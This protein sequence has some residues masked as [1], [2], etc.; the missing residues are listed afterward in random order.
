MISVS[1]GEAKNRLPF[2]LHLVESGEEVQIT[3]H[4]KNVASILS[5]QSSPSRSKKSRYRSSLNAW[6]QKYSS[7]LLSEEEAVYAFS[8]DSSLSVQPRHPEDFQ[9]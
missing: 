5:C 1:V 4:G 6:R 2:F 7:L 8:R 9:L 3:R